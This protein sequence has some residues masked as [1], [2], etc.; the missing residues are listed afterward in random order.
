MAQSYFAQVSPGLEE[1]LRAE[2][3]RLGARKLSTVEG[4]VSFQGTRKHLYRVLLKSRIA[5]RVYWS[6][7][8]GGAPNSKALFERVIRAPWTTLFTPSDEPL[9]LAIRVSLSGQTVFQ[10]TGEV[11]ALVLAGI[12]RALRSQREVCSAEWSDPTLGIE[13][14]LVR[15]HG[16]RVT[17]RLDAAGELLHRRGWREVE[18][19]APLRPTL[20]AAMLEL[21]QWDEVEPLIDPMCGAGTIPIE[22]ARIAS[23]RSPR[24]WRHYAC[25]RWGNFDEAAW[26]TELSE[27]D[28]S[29]VTAPFHAHIFASDLS[30]EA[31][32]STQQHLT[33]AHE[34]VNVNVS[35]VSDLA[36]PAGA[37]GLLLVNPP[38]GLRVKEGN[39]LKRLLNRFAQDHRWAGW[40][41]GLIYPRQLTPPMTMGLVATEL[42]RF[43]HGGLPVWVWRYTR[44]E[45]D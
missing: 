14:V 29:R 12:E 39:G 37:P 45:A 30:P 38:Y 21:L 15:L 20:A 11:E 17:I 9:R 3:K 23:G 16:G 26:E 5:S 27:G 7:A 10:G 43:Q 24:L 31:I 18:G 2:L 36:P 44:L 1:V 13:R 35:D 6:I 28:L 25:T 4:G 42:A 34:M 22:A 32:A 40:R 41:L 8:E 33:T 19:Q